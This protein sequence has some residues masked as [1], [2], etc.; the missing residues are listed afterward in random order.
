MIVS[1][2]KETDKKQYLQIEHIYNKIPLSKNKVD[3]FKD[4]LIDNKTIIFT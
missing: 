1:I 2:K 3:Y 4:I